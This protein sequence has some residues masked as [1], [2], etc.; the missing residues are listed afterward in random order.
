MTAV[1]CPGA[2]SFTPEVVATNAGLSALFVLLFGVTAEIFNATIDEN[3]RTIGGTWSRLT[4]GP[5][6]FFAPVIAGAV[7]V[8]SIG[9][10]HPR[11]Q[12]FF[13]ALGILVAVGFIYGFLAR[14]FTFDERGLILVLSFIIGIGLITYMTQGLRA[15][16]VRQRYGVPATV[17]MYGTAVVVAVGAVVI[18]RAM[19]LAP[20]LVFGFVASSFILRPIA[21]SKRDEAQLVFWPSVMLLVL[22][23]GAFLLLGEASKHANLEHL[24]ESFLESVL[25]VVFIVGLEGFVFTLLPLRF[26]NGAAMMRWNKWVWALLFGSA[27]FL[28]CQLLLNRDEAYAEAWSQTSIRILVSGL[29]LFMGVTA[30]LWL[31]FRH[32][33]RGDES[34]DLEE[35]GIEMAEIGP[36]GA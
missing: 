19:G 30:V 17:R 25:A 14:E 22:S 35:A 12:T 7:Y 6:R 15:I 2:L 11:L 18:S 13:H 21:L 8:D 10:G 28:W 4:A 9:S 1:P 26:M 31:Y 32:R 36:T 34:I 20:G 33:D 27:M 16:I 29:A 3:R 23:L 24:G 5:A